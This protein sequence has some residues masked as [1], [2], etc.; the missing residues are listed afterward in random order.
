LA[1][2]NDRSSGKPAVVITP[3]EAPK[4]EPKK[5]RLS[6]WEQREFTKL[7][8]QIAK[9]E[10]EKVKLEKELAHSPNAAYSQLQKLTAELERVNKSIDSTTER[11]LELA[12]FA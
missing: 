1:A 11:W 2:K 4:P 7:E 9:L 8:A 3:V 5:R 6:T 10:T 12:E